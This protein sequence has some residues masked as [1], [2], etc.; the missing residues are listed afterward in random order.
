MSQ[1]CLSNSGITCIFHTMQTYIILFSRNRTIYSVSKKET[2]MFFLISFIK[3]R[4]FWQN[5]VD[6]F[7]NKFTAKSH[8]RFASRL[9]NVFTLPCETWNAHFTCTTTEVSDKKNSRIYSTLTVV[10]K[11]T[12]FES[13][14]VQ[15][16]GNA[17]RK[18]VQNTHHWSGQ[19]E[20]VTEN[21]VV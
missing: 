1:C 17:A 19:N 20:T 10:S 8:K 5:L 15:S 14:W 2:K 6:C 18:D 4:L 16:V 11:F 7:L 3:L 21:E 13:S 12:R 9:N